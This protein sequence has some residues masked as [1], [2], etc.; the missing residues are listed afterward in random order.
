[1]ANHTTGAQRYNNRMDKIW[2]ECNARTMPCKVCGKV[3]PTYCLFSKGE[4]EACHEKEFDK[5]L[6]EKGWQ[7][8]KPDFVKT[9]N[10]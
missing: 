9:I 3:V 5:E 1:M 10:V 7:G 2:A 4:C 8:M 6:A